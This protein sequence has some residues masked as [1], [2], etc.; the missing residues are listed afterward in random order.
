MIARDLLQ[1][2]LRHSPILAREEHK[3]DRFILA[4]PNGKREWPLA[5]VVDTVPKIG[6]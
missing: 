2:E 3:T 1:I 5:T 4:G 6:A